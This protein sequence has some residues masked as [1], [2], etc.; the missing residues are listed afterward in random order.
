M[1]LLRVFNDEH[2][3]L[4]RVKEIFNIRKKQITD[5]M[6]FLGEAGR[7]GISAWSWVQKR[8]CNK[9]LSSYSEVEIISSIKRKVTG[10]KPDVL[11]KM[12]QAVNLCVFF[13]VD[14]FMLLKYSTRP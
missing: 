9:T 8:V 6:P 2:C 1:V 7:I 14:N 11:T 5:I 10:F 3:S 12:V 13:P 4:K